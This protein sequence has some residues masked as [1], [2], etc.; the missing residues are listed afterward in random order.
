MSS[1][2][3][4]ANKIMCVFLKNICEGN[5]S[6]SVFRGV[7][8]ISQGRGRDKGRSEFAL[9]WGIFQIFPGFSSKMPIKMGKWGYCPLYPPPQFYAVVYFIFCLTFSF[10]FVVTSDLMIK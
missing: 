9:L 1:S 2:A 3:K 8:I 5:V 7:A 6:Y 4:R 10:V